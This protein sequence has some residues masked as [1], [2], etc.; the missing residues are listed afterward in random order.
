M[1]YIV[2]FT[3]SFKTDCK[4]PSSMQPA[5][6][7]G[8]VIRKLTVRAKYRRNCRFVTVAALLAEDGARMAEEDAFRVHR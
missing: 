6:G 7:W 3:N 5:V 2:L 4:M 8:I 1:K